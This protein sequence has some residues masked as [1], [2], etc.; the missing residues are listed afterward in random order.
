MIPEPSL[1][2]KGGHHLKSNTDQS[3]VLD[4]ATP[5]EDK[6]IPRC[7]SNVTK[8]LEPKEILQAPGTTVWICCDVYDTGIGIPGFKT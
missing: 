3:T 2:S 8:D 4:N 1:A 7:H 6:N 5:E